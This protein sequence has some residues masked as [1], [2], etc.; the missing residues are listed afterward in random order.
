MSGGAC[1]AV[2]EHT[3]AVRAAKRGAVD[4]LCDSERIRAEPDP[5]G[6]QQAEGRAL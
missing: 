1:T 5:Q 4:L 3:D 2:H 6:G